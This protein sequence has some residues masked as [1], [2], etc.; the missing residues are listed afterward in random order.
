MVYGLQYG[1]DDTVL[2]TMTMDDDASAAAVVAVAVAFAV[3]ARSSCRLNRMPQW[4]GLREVLSP[5]Q[6]HA[7]VRLCRTATIVLC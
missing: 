1:G 5:R 4:M 3:E 6:A 7:V 2:L